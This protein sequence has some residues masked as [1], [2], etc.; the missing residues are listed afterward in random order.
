MVFLHEKVPLSIKSHSIA[1]TRRPQQRGALF[2]RF[3]A[4]CYVTDP[5]KGLLH[6][7]VLRTANCQSASYYLAGELSNDCQM[8]VVPFC[9]ET[10]NKKG[11]E[12]CARPT[13]SAMRPR[14]S[15][16]RRVRG[17]ILNIFV[18]SLKLSPD[19]H[20]LLPCQLF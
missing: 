6:G 5:I 8:C 14:G 20:R 12:G 11:F 15:V 9:M 19:I 18:N 2:F 13:S 3:G 7:Q 10:Y 1:D 17:C 4:E 16:V